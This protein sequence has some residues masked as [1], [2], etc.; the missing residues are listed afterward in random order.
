[1]KRTIKVATI[2]ALLTM[3]F[4]LSACSPRT[5]IT[6]GEFTSKAT[7]A[8]YTIVDAK[9]QYEESFIVDYK[10]AL[11]D[12]YQVEFCVVSTVEQAI[13][14]YNQNKNIFEIEKGNAASSSEASMSNYSK[15]TQTSNGF[16][17]VISRV[18]NTFIY[19]KVDSKHK[20]EVSG[21]IESLGY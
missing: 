11:K 6:A 12:G 8:G 18:D 16:Y 1:M 19:A 10:I 4:T 14:A 2:F 3:L 7:D 5:A 20:D 15:Y 13:A 17:Y 21:F 9:D